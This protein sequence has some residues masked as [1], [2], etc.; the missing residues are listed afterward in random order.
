MIKQK[1]N[2]NDI[3]IECRELIELLNSLPSIS[4]TE[5]CSGH[6]KEPYLVFFD[7]DD[8]IQLGRL[9]RAV[10]KNYSDGKW[11]IEC[12]CSDTNPVYGFLLRSNCVFESE[13]DLNESLD[14]LIE[15]IKYWQ[16]PEFDDYFK[17]NIW[18]E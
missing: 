12:C 3:D 6:Y 14:Y 8:F 4:T 15:N 11:R 1:Y 16:S 9:Y 13:N 5:C 18:T 2:I 7:C 10:N 17:N